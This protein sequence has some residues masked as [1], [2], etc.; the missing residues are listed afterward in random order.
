M[1]R[2]LCIAAFIV[3][4]AVIVWIGAGYFG[5]HPLALA[6]TIIIA[7]PTVVSSFFGMNVPV[8]FTDDGYGFFYVMVI[9]FSIS[10]AGAYA[11][12]KKDMF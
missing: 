8:P 6:M 9:A 12:W 4:A 3:G 5:S 11:L 7:I 1:N 2:K 10:I